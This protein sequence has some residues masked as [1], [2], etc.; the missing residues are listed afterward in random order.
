MWTAA[1]TRSFRI[2][3]LDALFAL[4]SPVAVFTLFRSGEWAIWKLPILMVSVIAITMNGFV[5]VSILAPNALVVSRSHRISQI[6]IPRL[7]FAKN[8]SLLDTPQPSTLHSALLLN[9]GVSVSSSNSPELLWSI[10][11]ECGAECSFE[12]D[13]ES[14]GISC[15]DMRS[16]EFQEGDITPFNQEP[17]SNLNPDPYAPA[18]TWTFYT[19]AESLGD[20]PQDWGSSRMANSFRITYASTS[21]RPKPSNRSEP[22]VV[23]GSP[24]GTICSFR[25]ARYRAT[26]QA[27]NQTKVVSSR[28]ISSGNSLSRTCWWAD[29]NGANSTE[30]QLYA[31]HSFNVCQ[32]FVTQFGI[33][34]TA[35]LSLR[36][37]APSWYVDDGLDQHLRTVGM[38]FD[39]NGNSTGDGVFSLDS[40]FSD[41]NKA[42]EELFANMTI[43]M[44]P[45]LGMPTTVSASVAGDF[46]WKANTTTLWFIYG[47]VIGL[48]IALLMYG[49]YCVRKAGGV[50]DRN[51]LTIFLA[52]RTRELD[53]TYQAVSSLEGLMKVKLTYKGGQFH[54]VGEGKLNGQ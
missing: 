50:L 41:L 43:G 34:P 8:I 10:P 18:A 22:L 33:G 24:K 12:F 23:A 27:V 51:F 21:I 47:P 7:D 45:Y 44:T 31:T 13:Y 42:L 39:Y 32:A 38:V 26:I 3:S 30:C 6:S 25:D 35:T 29:S 1:A 17:F 40:R 28:L 4:P 2:Q 53:T 15:R 52:T 16:E 36:A 9:T 48:S 46:V 37:A 49:F 54:V 14:P 19:A 5:L 20:A 11:Q